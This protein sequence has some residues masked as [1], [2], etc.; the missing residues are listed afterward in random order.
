MG[1][2]GVGLYQNDTGADLKEVFADLSRRPLGVDD[3]VAAVLEKFGCGSE[4]RSEDDIDLWLALADQLHLDALDHPD[5]MKRARRLVTGGEDATAKR[6][7]GMSPTDLSKRER[8]LAETLARWSSPHP[9][10]KR[11]KAA[12]EPEPFLLEIGDAWVYPA[13]RHAAL[14]FHV[15]DADL[16]GFMPDGWGAFAVADRWHAFGHRACY[17][18]VLAIP[19]GDERP[20]LADVCDARLQ[21]CT[22]STGLADETWTYPMIFEARLGKRKKGLKEWSAENVGTL[23]FDLDKV[24]EVMPDRLR[25]RYN[26][27][28]PDGLMWLEDDLTLSSYHRDASNAR[29]GLSWRIRPHDA[30]RIRDLCAP[31]T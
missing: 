11:R 7:L 2:W 21:E 4:P 15:K 14:P 31:A 23:A 8:V 27:N 5:T 20:S 1:A 13:M 17:L 25:Q 24:R 9:K 22:F 26:A 30:L 28:D 19:D 12:K 18:F 3:L 29:T 16:A 6:E 10:P